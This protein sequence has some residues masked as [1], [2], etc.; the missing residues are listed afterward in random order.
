MVSGKRVLD[1]VRHPGRPSMKTVSVIIPSGDS[2]RSRNLEWLAADLQMQSLPHDEVEVVCGVSPNGRARNVG[3][4]RTSGDI[5]VFLDDDV[6]LGTPDVLGSFVKYLASDPSLGLVGSSQLL[7]P[8]STPFR[9][10]S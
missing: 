10:R 8:H 6:R 2:S 5:L 7:P 1:A 9:R 4:E 3:V